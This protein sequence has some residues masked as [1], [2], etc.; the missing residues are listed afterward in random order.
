MHYEVLSTMRRVS[1]KHFRGDS[2]EP[3]I[4]VTARRETIHG[5]PNDQ[6]GR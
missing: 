6:I 3:E 5:D 1:R 2:Y 4:F